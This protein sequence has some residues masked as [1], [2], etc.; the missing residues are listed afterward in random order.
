VLQTNLVVALDV[1]N[2]PVRD[3][4]LA[5]IQS[6][7]AEVYLV[8][9]AAAG[10]SAAGLAKHSNSHVVYFT[11]RIEPAVI[12]AVGALRFRKLDK[13]LLVHEHS[14]DAVQDNPS[15]LEFNHVLSSTPESVSNQLVLSTIRKIR[16]K[17]YYG[18]DKCLAYGAHVHRFSLS[19]SDERKWFRDQLFEFVKSLDTIIG[20]PTDT[21]AQFALEVQEELLMNAIWDANPARRNAERKGPALLE[22]H[23]H[24]QV[25]WSFDGTLLAIGV[26]DPFGSFEASVIYKYLRFLFSR[27]RIKQVKMQQEGQGAG[28][29]LY[30][31]LERLSSLIITVEPGRATEVI[32]T[33]NLLQSPRLMSKQQ[34]SFQYFCV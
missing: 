7:A 30:M 26:R 5:L 6:C 31:V 29:G 27:D 15:L 13:V 20:R 16:E 25:E 4:L 19:N 12:G 8:D 1:R 22:P 9:P 23:E 28:I 10:K 32:A 3:N 21:F 24:V 18:V 34:R 2:G 11:D 14:K 17:D 33:L